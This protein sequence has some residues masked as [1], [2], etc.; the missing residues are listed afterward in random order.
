MPDVVWNF[1]TAP[2]SLFICECQDLA[3]GHEENHF[4]IHWV[5][6]VSDQVSNL[7]AWQ[8]KKGNTQVPK[9]V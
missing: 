1:V 7:L 6:Q 4:Y 3:V 5:L 2:S 9:D 8:I